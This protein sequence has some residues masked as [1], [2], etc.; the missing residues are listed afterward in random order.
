MDTG[1]EQDRLKAL[2]L[3]GRTVEVSVKSTTLRGEVFFF[4]DKLLI[5]TV[6]SDYVMINITSYD[7]IKVLDNPSLSPSQL[8]STLSSEVVKPSDV[9]AFL[10]E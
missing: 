8:K 6:G 10:L 4:N 2:N 3:L 1:E 7:D 9:L 5:L